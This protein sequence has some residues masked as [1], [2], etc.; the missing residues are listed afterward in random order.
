MSNIENKPKSQIYLV[1]MFSNTSEIYLNEIYLL[2]RKVRPRKNNFVLTGRE[3]IAS[4][5]F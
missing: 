3:Y 1:K 5:V 2:P 4:G